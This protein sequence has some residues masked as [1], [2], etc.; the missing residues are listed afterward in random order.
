MTQRRGD[1]R[2]DL[3][4]RFV[5]ATGLSPQQYLRRVRIDTAKRLLEGQIAPLYRIAGQVG[6]GD[7]RAF[8]RAIGP[9]PGCRW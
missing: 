9:W 6:Y 2:S 7:T 3:N 1:E 4:R 5:S 8:I